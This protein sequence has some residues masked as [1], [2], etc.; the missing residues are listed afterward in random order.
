MNESSTIIRQVR[1]LVAYYQSLGIDS[2]PRMPAIESLVFGSHARGGRSSGCTAPVAA[3]T[4]SVITPE[5]GQGE[6]LAQIREDLGECR[7]CRLH[8]NRAHIVFG[9]GDPEADLLVISDSPGLSDDESGELLTRMLVA[10]DRSRDRVYLT[11]LVKCLPPAGRKP[12]SEE[13]RTCL[14]F[15]HRQIAAVSPRVI[16]VMGTE[17]ARLFTEKKKSLSQLRGRFHDFTDRT[18]KKI[19]LIV[20]YHPD[21]LIKNQEMKK[22]SWA[23]LQMIH[24]K[25]QSG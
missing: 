22:A 8:E 15:L 7:R 24:R 17:A 19:P 10:I 5:P 20:T 13:I 12:Q 1:R 23:D 4:A 9:Q 11:S 3:A 2:Y 14:P 16:C 18:G 21:F 25:L 6:T